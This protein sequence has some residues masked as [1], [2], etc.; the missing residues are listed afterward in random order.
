MNLAIWEGR[1]ILYFRSW[2]QDKKYDI[3][4]LKNAK[5]IFRRI[6]ISVYRKKMSIAVEFNTI[7]EMFDRVTAKFANEQRPAIMHKV[8]GKYT[9]IS[10]LKL[11]DDVELFSC[12]LAGMGVQR[13]DHV[14]RKSTRL[15]SSH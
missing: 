6:F 1:K 15:N 11:R 4:L 13:A 5:A 7:S 8:D 3:L 2:K 12:G 9:G 10:Y 14:D